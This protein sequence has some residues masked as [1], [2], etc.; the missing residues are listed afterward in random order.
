MPVVHAAGSRPGR[1]DAA[2]PV[3]EFFTALGRQRHIATFERE[4]ATLRFDIADGE[5]VRRWLVIVDNGTV[6]VSHRNGR[7]D[8]VVRMRR[9]DAEAIVTGRINAQAAMLRGLIACQGSV[10]ALTM[11]QRCLPGPPDSTGRVAPITSE[12]VMAERRPR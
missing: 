4:S 2:D 6:A 5:R 8:A 1:P 10:G 9:A 11:F 3:G 12:Q 7:A